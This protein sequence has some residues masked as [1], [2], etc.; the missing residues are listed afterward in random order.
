MKQFAVC[1]NI[2][3]NDVPSSPTNGTN[4]PIQQQFILFN[5]STV[6]SPPLVISRSNTFINDFNLSFPNDLGYYMPPSLS[7]NISCLSNS[8]TCYQKDLSSQFQCNNEINYQEYSFDKLLSDYNLIMNIKIPKQLI[9]KIIDQKLV[10][11][12]SLTR[13]GSRFIQKVF[14][15]A[16]QEKKKL[17]LNNVIV[18]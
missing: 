12:M 7:S 16:T 17:C 13:D 1:D 15:Y 9:K 11:N 6:Q 14:S 2:C 4:H 8:L 3:S 10:V 5:H 18:K